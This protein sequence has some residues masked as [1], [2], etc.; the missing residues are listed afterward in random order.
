MGVEDLREGYLALSIYS[1]SKDSTCTSFRGKCAMFAL[2]LKV[3][4]SKPK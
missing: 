3:H 4:T 1:Q 2:Q